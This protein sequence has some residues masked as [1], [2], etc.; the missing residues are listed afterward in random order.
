MVTEQSS[1][2]S[3][4]A[5]YAKSLGAE[6][7]GLE[8]RSSARYWSRLGS[9]GLLC[10]DQDRGGGSGVLHNWQ[11]CKELLPWG[12][13]VPGVVAHNDAVASY[14]HSCSDRVRDAYLDELMTGSR[15]ATVAI[16]EA[17]S[18]SDTQNIAS[19]IRQVDSSR[20][21]LNAEK[22]WI[23]NAPV[24]GLAFV[25]AAH[26]GG[27]LDGKTSLIAVDTRSADVHASE[28]YATT[29][30]KS[31]LVGA[32][33]VDNLVIRTDDF[34]GGPGAG[35]IQM[36]LAMARERASVAAVALAT[37]RIIMDLTLK[38]ARQHS[39]RGG[40]LG[41]KQAVSHRLARLEARLTLVEGA[42]Q[43]VLSNFGTGR[44]PI[45]HATRLKLVSTELQ[46]SI[47]QSCSHLFGAESFREGTFISRQSENARVQG[48]YAGTSEIMTEMIANELGLAE[49]ASALSETRGGIHVQQ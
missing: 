15:I 46:N 44:I 24:V 13:D 40:S 36:M 29:C 19:T 20:W 5:K 21:V 14:I 49:D 17:H 12:L 34:V 1:T 3:K 28:P 27:A 39:V 16:T 18:G 33:R 25:M 22:R 4:I 26:D 30:L 45:N 31:T 41:G 8:T 37:S 42:F 6:W 9:D 23:T 11:L 7:M 47:A 10:Q 32:L 2:K 35:A 38:W 43:A 48:I